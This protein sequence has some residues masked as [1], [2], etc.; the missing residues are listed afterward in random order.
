[1]RVPCLLNRTGLLGLSAAALGLLSSAGT[2]IGR[3]D[4]CSVFR[5]GVP[6]FDQ[7]RS[8]LPNDGKMYCVPASWI[9]WMAFLQNNG[10]NGLMWPASGTQNWQAQAQYVGVSARILDMGMRMGTDPFDGTS[11]DAGDLIE[12]VSDYTSPDPYMIVLRTSVY[13]G[14]SMIGPDPKIAAGQLLM[15]GMVNLH[16]S[17][18]K[19]EGGHFKRHGGHSVSCFGVNN[20]CAGFPTL[21]WRDPGSS[22]SLVLQSTFASSTSDTHPVFGTFEWDDDTTD[23]Y[24]LIY[25]LDGYTGATKGFLTGVSTL[26]LNFGV[27]IQTDKSSL[28]IYRPHLFLRELLT[29]PMSIKLDTADPILDIQFLPDMVHAL[30]LTGGDK[31]RVWTVDLSVGEHKPFFEPN[32]PG[33]LAI[34]RFG[35]IFYC[36]GSVLQ[37][38]DPKT[39]KAIRG[40]ELS[41]PLTHL[42]YDDGRDELVGIDPVGGRLLQFDRWAHLTNDR[43]L[44]KEIKPGADSSIAIHPITRELFLSVGDGSVFEISRPRSDNPSATPKPL[45]GVK[46]CQ[47]LQ[48]LGDGSV[49]VV[50]DGSVREFRPNADG[51]FEPSDVSGFGGQKFEGVLRLVQ[52]RDNT[53]Q[54]WRGVLEADVQ[55]PDGGPAEQGDC[56]GDYDGTGFVDTDDFT[57]F[58]LDFEAGLDRA[59]VDYSGFVDTD[60][61]TYFVLAFEDGC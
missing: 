55:A 38:I 39:G 18:F 27:G 6:D 56:V 52:S 53:P 46:H 43:P 11:L 16:L 45:P 17:W 23:Y 42:V 4:I 19:P 48:F 5:A 1:M 8:V 26:M 31:P 7:K 44:P 35:D 30:A 24:A 14:T 51:Q 50:C 40:V 29:H 28:N 9:N 36:D 49:T 54:E 60:D 61:F 25:Q 2:A 22:D 37:M 47:S 58:V 12:Y 32:K 41:R 34:G 21:R 20:L 13:P 59:D 33:P 10:Y 57:S 3:G 15:G